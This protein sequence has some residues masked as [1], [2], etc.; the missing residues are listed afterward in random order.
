MASGG[1]FFIPDEIERK[2]CTKT[3][4]NM[5]AEVENPARK[6]RSP[7]LKGLKLTRRMND[8]LRDAA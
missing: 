8:D 1:V 6:K 5:S 2:D 3:K 4:I 7:L